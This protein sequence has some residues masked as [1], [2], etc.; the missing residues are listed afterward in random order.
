MTVRRQLTDTGVRKIASPT[1]GRLEIYDVLVPWMALRI[2]PNGHKSF[3]A[4]ARI[5]GQERPIRYTLGPASLLTVADARQ[6][7]RDAL[8]KMQAG[9]DPREEKKVQA[10]VVERRKRTAFDAVAEQYIKEH[11]AGLRTASRTA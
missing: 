2:T 7:A 3:V 5:K 1:S 8:L 9:I 4:R 6:R 10:A 11:V